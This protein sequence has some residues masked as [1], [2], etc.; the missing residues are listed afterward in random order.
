MAESPRRPAVI[1]LI[2]PIRFRHRSQAHLAI[3]FAPMSNTDN[4]DGAIGGFPKDDTPFAH[5]KTITWWAEALELFH[6]A[7]AR[8]KEPS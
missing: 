1:F 5:P 6:T 3:G 2:A 4:L 7:G 8:G